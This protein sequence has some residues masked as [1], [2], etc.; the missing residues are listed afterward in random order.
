MS[1]QQTPL[2]TFMFKV[3]QT[4]RWSDKNQLDHDDQNKETKSLETEE[5]LVPS[6][7]SMK[8]SVPSLSISILHSEFLSETI[9]LLT[10]KSLRS[11]IQNI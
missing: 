2:Q 9:S 3:V 11:F 6:V 5:L 10:L 8:V 7:L 1:E 4:D